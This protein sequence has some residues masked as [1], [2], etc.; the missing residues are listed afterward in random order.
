MTLFKRL[1]GVAKHENNLVRQK[2]QSRESYIESPPLSSPLTVKL[3]EGRTLWVITQMFSALIK[4]RL[5]CLKHSC[6]LFKRL[7]RDKPHP[8][9]IIFLS[10]RS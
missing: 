2:L 9:I 8:L 6:Q 5:I 10:L 7:F 3:E 1:V 4:Q